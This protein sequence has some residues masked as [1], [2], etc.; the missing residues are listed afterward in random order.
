MV[1]GIRLVAI[2]SILTVS[3]DCE[4]KNNIML[5]EMDVLNRRGKNGPFTDSPVLPVW[6]LLQL[7]L[8]LIFD[9]QDAD[10]SR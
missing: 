1:R 4:E 9:C 3:L 5:K 7:I 10:V 2:A 8:T 6:H